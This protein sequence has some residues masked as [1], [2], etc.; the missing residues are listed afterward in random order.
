MIEHGL[1]LLTLLTSVVDQ[2]Y[3]DIKISLSIWILLAGLRNIIRE[4]Q[5]IKND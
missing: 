4:P 2:Q 5:N 3:L 1:L